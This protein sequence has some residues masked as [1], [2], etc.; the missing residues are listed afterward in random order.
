VRLDCRILETIFLI[1]FSLLQNSE[2]KKGGHPEPTIIL[3]TT[4]G[5]LFTM[6]AL[7]Y[8]TG[9]F[10]NLHSILHT[11]T[12]DW[13]AVVSIVECPSTPTRAE[14]VSPYFGTKALIPLSLIMCVVTLY[15][16]GCIVGDESILDWKSDI[17]SSTEIS[18][19][20]EISM[21][22]DSKS[23][24]DACAL[25]GIKNPCAF[26]LHC[27]HVSPDFCNA[28]RWPFRYRTTNC[29]FGNQ[30]MTSLF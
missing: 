3:Q 14:Q 24:V 10:P 2:V 4:I 26:I 9:I 17:N 23:L 1:M 27:A 29:S 30:V 18:S 15:S 8:H 22:T 28:R 21:L 25:S 16:Q 6:T 7:P 5:L 19:V 13:D 20:S 11:L 12:P